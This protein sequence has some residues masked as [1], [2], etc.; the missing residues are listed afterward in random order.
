MSTP[1]F[2]ISK[3]VKDYVEQ[4]ITKCIVYTTKS[5][6]Y[7]IDNRKALFEDTWYRIV[8]N[9]LN[10]YGFEFLNLFDL[11]DIKRIDFI[12]GYR[13]IPENLY[14]PK[15]EYFGICGPHYTGSWYKLN[16]SLQNINKIEIPYRG[17]R[18]LYIPEH[19][20]KLRSINCY[21]LFYDLPTR[22]KILAQQKE[23]EWKERLRQNANF[24]WIE[25]NKKKKRTKAYQ[26]IKKAKKTKCKILKKA[27][28]L[29]KKIRHKNKIEE[30]L[31]PLYIG[32]VKIN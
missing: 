3:K 13:C 21:V 1:S 27:K 6:C 7:F 5:H 14:L 20:K 31:I 26:K 2:K 19:F 25:M 22:E 10:I 16:D 17:L 30:S 12:G 15:L 24:L 8:K 23:K 11:K 18:V 32:H 4:Q 9:E 28:S 29:K